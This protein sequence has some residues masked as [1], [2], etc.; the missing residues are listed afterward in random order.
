M[1]SVMIV[2]DLPA[3][4]EMLEAAINPAGYT[5]ECFFNGY[6]ALQRYKEQKFDIVLADISMK[7]MDGISLLK[8]IKTYD[9]QAM[10]IMLTGH[11]A[12]DSAMNAIKFGAFDYVEKPFRIDELIEKLNRA[13]NSTEK[14]KRQGQPLDEE[15]C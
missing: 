1:P 8:G 4:H 5:S 13:I 15:N 6:K 10:V 14:A 7:P 9:P 12:T 11:S 3:V 2:D